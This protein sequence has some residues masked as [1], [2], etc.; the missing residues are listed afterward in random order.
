M[1]RA[2]DVARRVIRGEY[3]VGE[4]RKRRLEN[5]GFCYGCV[6]NLVNAMLGCKY[7]GNCPGHPTGNFCQEAH[8]IINK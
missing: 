5:E 3:G 7:R 6:Q 1:C 4:E 2:C 8:N